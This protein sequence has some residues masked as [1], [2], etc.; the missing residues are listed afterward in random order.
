MSMNKS[1]EGKKKKKQLRDHYRRRKTKTFNTKQH[2]LTFLS[3]AQDKENYSEKW[4][5]LEISYTFREAICE[6]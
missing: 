3:K 2:I 4:R 1:C 5:K 6:V